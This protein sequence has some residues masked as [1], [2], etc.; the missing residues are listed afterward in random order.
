VLHEI[1]DRSR[2]PDGRGHAGKPRRQNALHRLHL[3]PRAVDRVVLMF[4][5]PGLDQRLGG[6]VERCDSER[7]AGLRIEQG[8]LVDVRR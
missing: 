5:K 6:S 4:G 7:E 2:A 3:G 8:L 1:R